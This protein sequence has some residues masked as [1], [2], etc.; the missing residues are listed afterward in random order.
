M[1]H[2]FIDANILVK[3]FETGPDALE[4][5]ELLTS[6]I[7]SEDITVWLP[8][9]T[10][11]EFWNNRESNVKKS[12]REFADNAFGR[13]IPLLVREHPKFSALDMQQQESHRLRGEIA[14]EL[15][16]QIDNQKTEA[17]KLIRRLFKGAKAINTD[18]DAIF[19]AAQRRALCHLPPGKKED[20]GDR[21]A[22]VGLLAKVPDGGNLNIISDDSDFRNEG[23]SDAIRPYLKWEWENKKNGE[24]FLWKRITEFLAPKYPNARS[25]IEL[26]RQIR[27]R[28]L[29]ESKSFAS[30]H[31]LIEE[32]NQ[33][34]RFRIDHARELFEIMIE[35]DQVGCI[36]SD[37]DVYQF[38]QK[39]KSD[40]LDQLDE[41]LQNKILA[42]FKRHDEFRREVEEHSQESEGR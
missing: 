41:E 22:W 7:E 16:Q 9:Q 21:L 35:N 42:L 27:I 18:D 24:V 3:F 13:S 26:E 33:L 17:D 23:F 14:K 40:F 34:K 37:E 1:H 8:E 12:I 25:S 29:R 28:Q 36:L 4:S 5:L 30:T 6:L 19:E 20:I 10:K 32:L 38:Y 11:R 2:I 15:E 39:L 31:E